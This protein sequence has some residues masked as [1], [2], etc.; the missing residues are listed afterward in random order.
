MAKEPT[1]LDIEKNASDRA[2]QAVRDFQ[3][4]QATQTFVRACLNDLTENQLL[5]VSIATRLPM[6]TLRA[7]KGGA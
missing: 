1:Q 5:W 3:K 6:G 4:G 7:L 2:A